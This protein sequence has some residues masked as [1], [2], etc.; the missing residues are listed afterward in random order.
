MSFINIDTYL[1]GSIDMH[2]HPGITKG[3]VQVD[4]IKAAQT[5]ALERAVKASQLPKLILPI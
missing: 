2:V 1:S 4:V 5:A 3:I